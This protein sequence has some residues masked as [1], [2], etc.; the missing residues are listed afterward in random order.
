MGEFGTVRHRVQKLHAALFFPI[1]FAFLIIKAT[2]LWQR[3]RVKKSEVQHFFSEPACNQ[4][5]VPRTHF[6]LCHK[7][8]I[9][10]YRSE[11]H[12]AEGCGDPLESHG[13]FWSLLHQNVVLNKGLSLP[14][15]TITDREINEL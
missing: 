13:T 6:T 7:L 9:H 14:I 5:I 10:G 2:R 8:D 3:K 12:S 1:F 15:S 4:S 11:L